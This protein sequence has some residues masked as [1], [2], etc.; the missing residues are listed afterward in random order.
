MYDGKRTIASNTNLLLFSIF[1]F[2]RAEPVLIGS[3]SPALH[4]IPVIY[5]TNKVVKYRNAISIR[6]RWQ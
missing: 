5:D 2:W 1:Y 4:Y 6:S 3:G